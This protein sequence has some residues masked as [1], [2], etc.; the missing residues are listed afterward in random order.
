MD[1]SQ[2]GSQYP[3]GE[4]ALETEISHLAILLVLMIW[5]FIDTKR[6]GY[7]SILTLCGIAGFSIF[8]QE[9]YADW[10]A[11]LLWSPKFHML[12]WGPTPFTTPLK[13]VDVA[14]T[15]PLFM[16]AAFTV[17]LAITGFATK[18]LPK[19]HPLIV[20][21]MVAGPILFAI[22]FGLETVAVAQA[23]QWTYVDVLG[24]AFQ[25]EKGQQPILYPGIP[26]GLF[27]AV[28][29][30]LIL[31]KDA[32]GRPVF[33]RLAK[34]ERA[35]AGWRRQAR[36]ALSWIVTWNVSYWLFLCTPLIA[37]RLLFGQPNSLVP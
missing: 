7:L 17:M 19:I 22:N 23:G 6:R 2:F 13:P 29:C 37:I 34:T 5:A 1:T 36:R 10:G 28:T 26:F 9:F 3:A 32:N 20:C 8:W 30:Y 16:C 12:P 21:L 25:T 15:Y 11:Y 31:Q 33:E 24:P 18:K 35:P 14:I 4:G 27:G